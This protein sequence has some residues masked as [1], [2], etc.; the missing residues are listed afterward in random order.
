MVKKKRSNI[1]FSF[2]K[3]KFEWK[4]KASFLNKEDFSYWKKSI[5][6]FNFDPKILY[7]VVLLTK[8]YNNKN[9]NQY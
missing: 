1:T 3:M 2:F 4:I 8:S 6:N 5:Y 7:W 9:K